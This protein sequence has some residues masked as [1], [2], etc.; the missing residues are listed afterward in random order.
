MDE[1]RRQLIREAQALYFQQLCAHWGKF[2]TIEVCE[3]AA[4]MKGVHTRHL[5]D[6]VINDEGDGLDLSDENRMLISAIKVG[7]LLTYPADSNAPSDHTEVVVAS[8]VPWLRMH[9]YVALADGLQLAGNSTRDATKKRRRDT[10]DPV[11]ELAQS[12]CVDPSDTSEV[13]SQMQALAEDGQPPLLASVKE[14]LKYQKSGEL[15]HFTRDAL[16]KRLHPEKRG[17]PGKRR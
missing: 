11:I 4:L 2:S 1:A 8:F 3:A 15:A 6:I 9:G 16:N 7:E 13:W 5:Q 14:G 12:R 17:K 10:I